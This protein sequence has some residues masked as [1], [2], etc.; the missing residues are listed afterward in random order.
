MGMWSYQIFGDDIALDVE[1]TFNEYLE[2]GYS[3]EDAANKVLEYFDYAIIEDRH[4]SV[5]VFLALASVQIEKGAVN[6]VVKEKALQII[7]EGKGLE[8]FN[9]SH[10]SKRKKEYEELKVKL[11]Q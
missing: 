6:S 4:S 9:P 3:N 10:R 1:D 2:D 5:V 7:N 8:I 11:L